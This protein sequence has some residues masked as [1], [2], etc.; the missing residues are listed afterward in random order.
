MI[1]IGIFIGSFASTM[2]IGGGILWAPYLILVRD[3][4]PRLAVFFSFLIQ[5]VGMGSAAFRNFIKKQ[6]LIKFAV[7]ATP[8]ILIGAASGAF[9]NQR[10]ANIQTLEIGLGFI[11]IMISIA[12]AFQREKYDESLNI[13]NTISPPM[14]FN[15][16]S[17]LF[18][19]ISGIFSIG[20]GDFLIPMMRGK[21]KIPMRYAVGTSLFFNFLLAVGGS[22]FHFL[23]SQKSY[24]LETFE[25][26]VYIWPGVMIGGQLGPYLSEKISDQRLKEVFIFVMMVI[27]M[28]LIYQA[29]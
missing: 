1:P 16:S 23:M 10:L 27:G 29:L 6:L 26:L 20:I 9:I 28:H 14:K 21:L 12:F 11:A 2:G 18:G 5:M 3:M 8:F 13:D 25:P 7:K 24:T 15:L 4:D 17:F 22:I 19:N